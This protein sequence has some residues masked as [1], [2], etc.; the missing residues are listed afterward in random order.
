MDLSDIPFNVPV[1]IQMIRKK[2][3]SAESSR[4]Q[5]ASCLKDDRDIYEHVILHH[6]RD[7]KV[8]IESR[9]NGRFLQVRTSGKCVFDPTEPGEW[10]LF[11]METNWKCSL[12]FVSCHTGNVLQCADPDIVLCAN[13]DHE[14]WKA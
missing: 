11:T 1:I 13:Q 9:R 5:K 10:E 2:E 6:V 7:D 8:A 14:S 4:V 3:K 12:F